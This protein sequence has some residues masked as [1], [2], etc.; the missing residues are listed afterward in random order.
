[1]LA[2]S[3][4]RRWV[5][6]GTTSWT[7]KSRRQKPEAIQQSERTFVVF[8]LT[9]NKYTLSLVISRSPL[10]TKRVDITR[11][12]EA[13][14]PQSFNLRI[15]AIIGVLM[16]F[17]VLHARSTFISLRWCQRMADVRM[18]NIMYEYLS[19]LPSCGFA[20]PAP[21]LVPILS[22]VLNTVRKMQVM[23]FY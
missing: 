19:Y 16:S 14:W 10:A 18:N 17:L 13:Y 1:M 15:Q 21:C 23:G 9:E 12:I 3:G 11:L 7:W 8:V 20:E 6:W 2:S 22:D 4:V 5:L